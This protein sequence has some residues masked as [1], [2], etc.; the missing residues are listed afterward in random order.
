MQWGLFGLAAWPLA[1]KPLEASRTADWARSDPGARRHGVGARA[2]G[3]LLALGLV[4]A[5]TV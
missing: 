2:T 1:I 3:L 5:Q 4:L